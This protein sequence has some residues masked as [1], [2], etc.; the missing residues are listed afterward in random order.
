MIAGTVIVFG[1]AG[2]GAGPLVQA[3]LDRGAG[4]GRDPADLP[5]RL[6]LPAGPPPAHAPPAPQAV[7]P[8]VD[9][10]HVSGYYRRYSGDLADLG[11]GEILAWT[12]E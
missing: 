2:P 11:K 10:R 6:H 12:A 8:A 7:R 1:D 9:E 4:A 5:L 3:R